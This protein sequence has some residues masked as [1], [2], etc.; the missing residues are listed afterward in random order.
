MALVTCTAKLNL[1]HVATCYRRAQSGVD[2]AN[3]TGRIKARNQL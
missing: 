1:P 3:K 2:R